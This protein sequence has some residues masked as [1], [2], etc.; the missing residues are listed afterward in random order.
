[1][2]RTMIGVAVMQALLGALIAT[3]PSTASMPGGVFRALVFSG[4]F[5]GLWLVSAAFFRRASKGDRET[6]AVY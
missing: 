6:A 4:V 2:A 5:A 1:M 3:A